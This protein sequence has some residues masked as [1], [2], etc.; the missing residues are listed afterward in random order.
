MSFLDQLA[1]AA[2]LIPVVGDVAGAAA[3]TSMYMND[4]SSRTMG[5]YAMSGLGMLPFVP[6]AGIIRTLRRTLKSITGHELGATYRSKNWKTNYT[7][8]AIHDNGDV[9]VRWADGH[10]TT[11][12]TPV[13]K[14]KKVSP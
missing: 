7:V 14:D 6:S 10:K 3:D 8:E 13:G 12:Q 9:T 5:N 4:P 1:L 2:A 11:H